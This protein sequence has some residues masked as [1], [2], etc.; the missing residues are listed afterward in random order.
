MSVFFSA[1]SKKKWSCDKVFRYGCKYTETKTQCIFPIMIRSCVSTVVRYSLLGVCLVMQ[2]SQ[3]SPSRMTSMHL[4]H[5]KAIMWPFLKHI[6]MF[7][8]ICPSECVDKQYEWFVTLKSQQ[9]YTVAFQSWC[10]ILQNKS[11]ISAEH[12]TVWLKTVRNNRP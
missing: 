4:K 3:E 9:Q 7:F 1:S 11:T 8:P 10:Q 12:K 5:M 6:S 2:H